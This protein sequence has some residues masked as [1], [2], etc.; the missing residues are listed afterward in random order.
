VRDTEVIL[1]KNGG[2]G[3]ALSLGELLIR[4]AAED[5]ENLPYEAVPPY[6]RE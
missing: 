4:C 5:S 1:E 6:V 2:Q 3:E